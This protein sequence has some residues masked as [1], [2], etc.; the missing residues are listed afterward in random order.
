MA[1]DREDL[2]AQLR[3]YSAEDLSLLLSAAGIDAAPTEGVEALARRVSRA[4]WWRTHTPLGG[5]VWPSNLDDLVDAVERRAKLELGEGDVWSRLA[6]LSAICGS[7][8]EP[9][10]EILRK[11]APGLPWG[12]MAGTTAAGGAAGVRQASLWALRLT[13]GEI[14]KWLPLIPK[15]GPVYLV[16]RQ[17]V[18]TAAVVSAPLGAALALAAIN[19]ALGAEYARALPLLVG[20]GALCGQVNPDAQ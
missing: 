1:V 10:A 7:A 12:A 8:E 9:D 20:I 13:S 3:R 5:L 4:L 19:G 16:V 17:G 14:G 15:V 18:R 11:V 2:E 6:R